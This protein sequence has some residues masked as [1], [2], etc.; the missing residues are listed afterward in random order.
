MNGYVW[1]EV[2]GGIKEFEQLLIYP[3]ALQTLNK[4][5]SSEHAL[6]FLL[7]ILNLIGQFWRFEETVFSL[8][9]S[10]ASGM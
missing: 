7:P 9:G 10:C 4:V 6:T 5:I 8:A 1:P 3:I 2:V